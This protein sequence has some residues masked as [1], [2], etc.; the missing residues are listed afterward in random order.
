MR[1]YIKKL[2]KP[3]FY[4]LDKLSKKT[5]IK[6]F[7]KY[8]NWLGID[9][10]STDTKGTWISPS[11]FFDSSH[12]DYLKIGKRV[13]ISF[14]VSILVHDF[15][16]VHAARSCGKEVKDIICKKVEIGDNVF[17]GAHSLI[18]P[19]TIIGNNCIIGGSSLVKGKC[20]ENSVYAGNPCRRICSIQEYLEKHVDL[21]EE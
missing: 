16:I 8:L 14:G 19:G 4:V 15:S 17:I 20:M 1:T 3:L 2:L 7:P 12:Y 10:D 18:L 5:Y 21:L 6:Y 13:T 11:T 9:I